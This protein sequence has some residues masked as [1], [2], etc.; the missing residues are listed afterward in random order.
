MPTPGQRAS[1]KQ[2]AEIAELLGGKVN[3]GSGNGWRHKNDVRTEEFSVE[4]K[5]TSAK[6]YSLKRA[7]LDVAE[8]HALA[9][10]KEML[11]VVDIDGKRY[12]IMRD[13]TFETLRVD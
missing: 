6:S 2:E 12:F 7:E 4:C 5:T 9:D 13:Y 8:T 10:G 3:S 1:R 11:F